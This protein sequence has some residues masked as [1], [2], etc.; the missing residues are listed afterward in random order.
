MRTLWLTLALAGIHWLP[1]G[2]LFAEE[3]P[4]FGQKWSLKSMQ[5]DGKAVELP[6]GT[7]ATLSITPEGKVSGRAPVNR[8][9]GQ[10]T[11][12]Q[13]GRCTWGKAFGAT[14][15]AGPPEAMRAESRYFQ[16]LKSTSTYQIENGELLFKNGETRTLVR[17]APGTASSLLKGQITLK[18]AT[19]RT[20]LPPKAKIVVSLQDVSLA[21]APARTIAT[22]KL[23]PGALPLSYELKYDASK[24][25]KGRRY[26]LSAR[27]SENGTL[28][29]L[30]DTSHPVFTDGPIEKE[31]KNI[32]VISVRTK[33]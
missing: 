23:E 29:Y 19:K 20:A 16:I 4:A 25:Q 27:I 26:T 1:A 11:L 14:R 7:G 6:A 12:G 24:I 15:M 2:L 30:N 18:G 32:E 13:D 10:V 8:Y 21:D 9:F 22:R 33:K 28:L 5:S 3:N 31:A 17:F